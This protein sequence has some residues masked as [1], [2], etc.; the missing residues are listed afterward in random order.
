LTRGRLA[1]ALSQGTGASAANRSARIDFL[2]GIAILVVLVLHFSLTYDL[3]RS[4]LSQILPAGWI[5]SAVINGNYGVTIFFVISGFLITSNNLLRYGRLA[6]VRLRQF[7]AYRFSRI[8]PPLLLALCIILP[9]GLIGVPSFT[10]SQHGHTLPPA[11]F[12]IAITSVL[13]FWHNVLMQI[14]GYFNYCLNIYWS[15]SV[16]EVFYLSFPLA[17]TLLKRD[18]LIIALCIAAIVLGPVYRSI[19]RD[20][21]IFFLYAYPA[22][23]DAIAFGCLAALLQAK[24]PIGRRAGTLLRWAG[25]IGLAIGYFAGIDGHEIFGFSLIALCTVGL[26]ANGFDGAAPNDLDGAA[27]GRRFIFSRILGWLGRHSYELYLFHIIL[28]AGLRDLVP[29]ATLPMALKLPLFLLYLG[30]SGLIAAMAARYFA[31]P[32]NAWLRRRLA[33]GAPN[34]P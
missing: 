5:H 17:C 27:P 25:G 11:F 2:R 16:E 18:R 9:L 15:L 10:N 3:V 7:Y 12:L 33:S 1:R 21:E 13:T 24:F 8:V 28:L 22:C 19:H 29:K 6:D 20:N 14:V 34:M 30:L 26:L 31:D 4:P 23:F 32:L